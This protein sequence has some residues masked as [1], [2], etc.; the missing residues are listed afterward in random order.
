MFKQH[1]IGETVR[2]DGI[3]LHTG[4][5]ASVLFHP[6]PPDTGIVIRRDRVEFK[7]IFENVSETLLSTN[8]AFNG[9]AVRTVEHALAAFSGL[10]IH[11][12]VIEVI[13]PELPIMDGSA[14]EFVRLLM[15]AGVVPQNRLQPFLRI[16]EPIVF[17][18]GNS[19][20]MAMPHDGLR[21]T[22]QVDFDHP[23]IRDNKLDFT[24]SRRA[25][26][27]DLCG[28]RTF[29][30]LKDVDALR[31]RGLAQGGSMDNAIVVGE[32][33]VLNRDGLR[34]KDEFVR[35]KALDLIGDLALWGYPMEGHFVANKSGHR[36]H[37]AFLHHLAQHPM[38]WE[39]VNGEHPVEVDV[40]FQQQIAV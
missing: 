36:L 7:A 26:V 9:T 25:F 3:G 32:H 11:N 39:M 33:G 10:G 35:H 14:H 30:F 21:V 23:A 4:H 38:N 1:T 28:A 22:C 37:V 20:V 24:C 40:K 16:R 19:Y 5:P 29:G 6:A 8:L 17:A 2:A 18:D 34:F 31:A 12:L 27:E 15:Q 13:G